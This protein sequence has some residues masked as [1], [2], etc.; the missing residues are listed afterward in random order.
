MSVVNKRDYYEVLGVSRDVDDQAL[1]GAYR[2]LALKYHPDRNPEDSD[3]EE[4]FKEAAEA[5]GVLSDPQK[6]AAYDR[7]GHQGVQNGGAQGFDPSNFADFG[8]ILGDLFGF[9]DLFGG[10]GGRRRS[11]VQRGEDLR[12][13][14]QIVL[15]DAI[16]GMSA[17]IQVPRM[18]ACTRCQGT[19]AEREDGMVT[20][21]VC[22]GRGEVLY[23]QGFLSVRRTCGQCNGRGQIVRRPCTQCRGEGR[24]RSDRKLKVNI[25]AGVENGTRLRLQNEGQP[26]PNGGPAGDLYV[27][28]A[29]KEHPVFERNGDDLHCV[30]PVNVA[31]AA[32]GA[33][34]TLSTFD[35]P[36]TVKIPEGTA[37][38][39]QVRLRGLGVPHLQSH[40]R[41]D[42]YVHVEVKIPARLTR[43]Q[44]R[45]FEQLR[46]TLPAENEP[47]EKGILD[48]VKDYF[49]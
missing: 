46:E 33:E 30:V 9:G 40:G 29:V 41:G 43:E 17:D 13:D 19:G 26:G 23:Q 14:L 20:C 44:R 42:L 8:D 12:F 7:F 5:Y 32:L 11:R 49:M 24:I 37:S 6:R 28:V 36:Q 38:G 1:K 35:G 31:Q 22:R 15:E 45:L 4:R 3:A 39:H 48:K 18:D 47:K 34:I 25:P 10:G 27:V 2:K 21:S 16:R